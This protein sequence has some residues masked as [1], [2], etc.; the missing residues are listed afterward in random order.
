[1]PFVQAKAITNVNTACTRHLV[2]VLS[3]GL[4]LEESGV[5][6]ER[7]RVVGERAVERRRVV[8]HRTF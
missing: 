4:E 5:V 2:K 7:A 8:V 3:V 6:D 1:M